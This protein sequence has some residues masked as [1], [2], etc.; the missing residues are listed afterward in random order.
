MLELTLISAI[1]GGTPGYFLLGPSK[2]GR[3]EVIDM[4]NIRTPVIIEK[5]IRDL[6]KDNKQISKHLAIMRT[7]L[8]YI[9]KSIERNQG[10]K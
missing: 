3:V 10:E 1:I 8:D 7:Q 5:A 6:R 4:I 2:P 9:S